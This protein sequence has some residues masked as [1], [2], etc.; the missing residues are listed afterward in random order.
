M[1]AKDYYAKYGEQLV[2]AD[3]K[4]REAA[5]LAVM[6]SFADESKALMDARK[7]RTEKAILA[8]VEE[9]NGRWNALC[10]MLPVPVLRRNGW[11][12]YFMSQLAKLSA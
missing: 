9:I 3:E 8:I 7:P 6:K 5:I 10:E 1:K 2:S 4:E 12:N 11:K